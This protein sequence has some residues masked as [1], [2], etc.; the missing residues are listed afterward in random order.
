MSTP[1]LSFREYGE[2]RDDVPLVLIHGLFGASGNW[3][4]LARILSRSRYC[5]VPDLRNHGGSPWDARMDYPAMAGDIAALLRSRGIEQAHLLGHSM[6]GKAAMW[7][8]LEESSLVGSLIIVDIAP[9]AYPERFGTL[10]R[11]LQALPLDEVQDRRDAQA[12]LASSIPS[13]KLRG[14]LLTNLLP[15]EG[16][17][18]RWR[19]NLPV[20]ARSMPEILG[21]PDAQ[22]RQFPG[23]ALF[24]YGARS[25]YLGADVLSVVRALF[26]LA[27]LRAVPGAGH[28]VYSDQPDAFLAAVRSF[29]PR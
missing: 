3:H 27:R 28:W 21:F 29:L 8:A 23:P 22:G 9:V 7:L 17:G 11:A 16:G 12:R 20:L 13:E 6:G 10:I 25:D 14:Y 4:G 18:W 1:A 15:R 2:R 19:I 5:L 24:L 26:P